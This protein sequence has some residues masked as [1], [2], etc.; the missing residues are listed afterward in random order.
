[1][2]VGEQEWQIRESGP[3]DAPSTVLLFPGGLC[4]AVFFDAAKAE[5]EGEPVRVVAATVPGFGR[6][7][8]PADLSMEN[9]ARLAGE[10]AAAVGADVIGGHSLGGN[11]AL[12][13]VAAGHFR[14]PVLLLSPTFCAEDEYKALTVLDRIGRVPGVGPLVWR[15]ALKGMPASMKKE[16][17]AEYAEVL[18][19]DLAN[20]DPA[21]CRRNV[22]EYYEYL[23][24]H[25]SVAKRLC[26]SGVK[27][28][29]VFGDNDEIGLRD[30][31]RELLEA[32]PQI[33]LTT[34][35]EST[36]MLLVEQPKLTAEQI[37]A[38]VREPATA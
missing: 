21:F 37:L 22:R 23:G 25:G 35:P 6:T 32:A 33:T 29:V 31:E 5:L 19:A 2:R 1:V 28:V 34:M 8:P 16:L 3:A 36:H 12:E 18:A 26:D 7:P 11:V 27:A 14:G 17:P 13:T 24:R 15:V 20:N 30:D 4:S 10:L 9:Y 38:L